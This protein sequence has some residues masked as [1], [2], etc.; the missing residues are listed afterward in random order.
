MQ[1]P[2]LAVGQHTNAAGSCSLVRVPVGAPANCRGHTSLGSGCDFSKT[3]SYDFGLTM[4]GGDASIWMFR[5]YGNGI[6]DY[7]NPGAAYVIWAR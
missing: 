5:N 6:L 2:D 1:R 7:P 4:C 3:N